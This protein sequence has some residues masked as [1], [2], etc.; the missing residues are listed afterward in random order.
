MMA[1]RYAH[2]VVESEESLSIEVSIDLSDV[3]VT[4]YGSDDTGTA[5]WLTTA[6][7]RKLRDALDAYLKDRGES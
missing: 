4:I 7:A 2:I 5:I 1:R 3:A 6:E